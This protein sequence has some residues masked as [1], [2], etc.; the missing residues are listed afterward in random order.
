MTH[1][2]KFSAV[3][4]QALEK[5][6]ASSP[7]SP[8]ENQPTPTLFFV[9]ITAQF[10]RT[11][12][13]GSPQSTIP[14]NNCLPPGTIGVPHLVPRAGIEPATSR[15][16][17]SSYLVFFQATGAL[18]LRI[19]SVWLSRRGQTCRADPWL[20]AEI[21]IVKVGPAVQKLSPLKVGPRQ[22]YRNELWL[23]FD[24]ESSSIGQ[25]VQKLSP[26]KVGPRFSLDYLRSSRYRKP[27]GIAL[28]RRK[29]SYRN[30]SWL[31]FDPKI[32]KIRPRIPKLSHLQLNIPNLFIPIF[33]VEYLATNPFLSIV[34]A[35]KVLA[36]DHSFHLSPQSRQSDFSFKSYST[37]KSTLD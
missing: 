3:C 18:T 6:K 33:D 7:L 17:V 26:L 11:P 29:Q 27:L 4:R 22:S 1:H 16:T 20:L 34:I 30:K 28:R 31:S 8:P 19:S 15:F 21:K 2:N 5:V 23:S 35:D 32:S 37:S 12:L 36:L 13:E 9:Q 24:P 14:S 10:I 25:T